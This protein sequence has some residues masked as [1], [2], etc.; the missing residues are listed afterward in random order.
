MK[1]NENKDLISIIV[2]VYNV[3]R[4]IR[5]CLDSI[6]NQTY[7]NI[8]VI[9][10]DDC[11]TDFSGRI[12]DEYAANDLRVNVIHKEKNQGLS[13][14]RNTGMK[15]IK[16]MYVSFIDSDDWV[17]QTFIECLYHGMKQYDAD[18][19]Q[20][21]YANVTDDRFRIHKDIQSNSNNVITGKQALLEL[22]SEPSVYEG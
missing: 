14:A 5:K 10:V 6:L 12:C 1:Q 13:E 4:Y 20:C 18:I 8:E 9:C 17:D 3:E 7:Y 11:S 15:F 22:Y 21:N 2:P 19:A 16:G